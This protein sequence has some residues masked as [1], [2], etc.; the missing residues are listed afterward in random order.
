VI[1]RPQPPF[2]ILRPLC[3]C[4]DVPQL[5]SRQRTAITPASMAYTRALHCSSAT[6][7]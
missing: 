2:L 4:M 1:S 6:L 7:H 3:A 5:W